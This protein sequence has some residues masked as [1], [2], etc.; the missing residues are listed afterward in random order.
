MIRGAIFD[1]DGTLLDSMGI[2][3]DAGARYL[4]S[5]G[6]KT[7]PELSD[8]LWNMSIPEGA[9]YLKETYMLPLSA[10][11][12]RQGI[13]DVVRDFYCQEVLLKPGVFSFLQEMKTR[14]IPMVI[15]TSSDRSYL[16][17][18]F[19]R[20]GVD[21]FFERIFTCEEAGAG[22]ESPKI[23]LD[24]AACLKLA[25]E[26]IWVFEDALF[27]AKTAKQAGF[28]V[29]GVYDESSK[30]DEEKLRK[31]CDTYIR[32]FTEKNSLL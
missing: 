1:A 8:I 12:I 16:E 13:L 17:T 27:A 32:N 31:L 28:R 7:P 18:A 9:A 30:T 25:P 21:S 15:A 23:Y 26:E 20:L 2:W 24:A 11:E 5:F 10:E 29:V 6:K 3:K 19:R 14:G 22:K 4:K